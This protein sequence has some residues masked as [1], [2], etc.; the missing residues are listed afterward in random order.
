MNTVFDDLRFVYARRLLSDPEIW[1]R[2]AEIAFANKHLNMIAADQTETMEKR[3]YAEKVAKQLC[4]AGKQPK[5]TYASTTAS[6]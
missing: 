5:V 3:E 2:P 1:R 4:M 6:Q